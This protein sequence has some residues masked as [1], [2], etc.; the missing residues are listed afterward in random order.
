[1]S[2]TP[3]NLPQMLATR[4]SYDGE[5]QK[6]LSQNIA[7]I[8]TPGYKAQDLVP[9]NFKNVLAAKTQQ[10][11]MA[12]TSDKHINGMLPYTQMFRNATSRNTFERTPVGSTVVVEEQMMKVAENATDYQMT[13][14]LYKKVSNLFK[15][16][17][18]L[19]P[20]A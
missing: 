14:S 13:S 2:A 17:L 11:T 4:M 16:A 9:L 6:V 15:E 7:S 20:A 10:I 19:Q 1:M 5:R 12:V 8:D 18:G 3:L